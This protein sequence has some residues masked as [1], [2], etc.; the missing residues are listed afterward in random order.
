MTQHETASNQETRESILSGFGEARA[1]YQQV[2]RD[3]MEKALNAPDGALTA[4]ERFGY[5]ITG[6]KQVVDQL[7]TMEE[8]VKQLVGQPIIAFTGEK[9]NRKSSGILGIIGSGPVARYSKDN[10][11]HFFFCFPPSSRY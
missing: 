9:F 6:S 10:P 4:T 8:A 1:T 5:G 11:I 3:L 7:R 2:V